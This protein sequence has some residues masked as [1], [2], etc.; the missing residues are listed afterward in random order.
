[1]RQT[2]ST[3]F[4]KFSKRFVHS[5]TDFVYQ[6]MYRFRIE[7]FFFCFFFLCSI[8]FIFYTFSK[9]VASLIVYSVIQDQNFASLKGS[10]QVFH[11]Y[12]RIFLSGSNNINV[13]NINVARSE[14]H[15]LLKVHSIAHRSTFR[16]VENLFET[17][18]VVSVLEDE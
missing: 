1:M 8:S 2:K 6:S 14:S 9:R 4:D 18:C 10:N 11:L 12:F 5:S 13:T 7:D 17:R 3:E 16:L 15:R